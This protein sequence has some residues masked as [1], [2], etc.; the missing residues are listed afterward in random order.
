MTA[1]GERER[2]RLTTAVE[3][4]GGA[5][6]HFRTGPTHV[7]VE[8]SN[9]DQ[10]WISVLGIRCLVAR[11]PSDLS[12]QCIG[13]VNISRPSCPGVLSALLKA[14]TARDIIHG[15][16]D[17]QSFIVNTSDDNEGYFVK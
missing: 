7:A 6:V 3:W 10:N 17:Q 15:I 13:R 5:Q 11:C 9:S 1:A 14:T 2:E 4:G 12:A 8:A 16:R